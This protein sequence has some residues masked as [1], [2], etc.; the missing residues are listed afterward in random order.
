[1]QRGSVVTGG[2]MGSKSPGRQQ[3]RSGLAVNHQASTAAVGGAIP[4]RRRED[5]TQAQ[6]GAWMAERRECPACRSH[7]VA[8]DG[9]HFGGLWCLDCRH[10][11]RAT[12][13]PGGA[14]PE[15]WTQRS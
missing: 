6:Y 1:M 12:T 7:N 3:T 9:E 14:D 10:E 15:W 8:V 5:V 11:W 4:G 2:P 13:F